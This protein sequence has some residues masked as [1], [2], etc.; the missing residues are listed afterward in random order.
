PGPRARAGVAA[1]AL[2]GALQSLAVIAYASLL[3]SMITEVF[4]HHATLAS[5][6]S[7]LIFFGLAVAGRALLVWL[8]EGLGHSLAARL[9]VHLRSPRPRAPLG[10]GPG[11]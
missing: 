2:C 9:L 3:A 11:P 5:L 1:V 4:Q 7:Q 6:R 10:P 8:A